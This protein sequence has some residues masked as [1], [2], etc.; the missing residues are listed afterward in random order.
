MKKEFKITQL[1]TTAADLLEAVRPTKDRATIITLSGDLGAGK[2]TL[3]QEIARILGVK[4]NIISPTFVI[5]KSYTT[6]HAVFK[7]LVHI[8]AYRLNSSEELKRLG[9][10]ELS[11]D[12]DSLI[13]LEWP[14]RVPE[15]LDVTV[16]KVA[17]THIDEDTRK[18]EFF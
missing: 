8:D 14:E 11:G 5:M 16:Q 17:L 18:I 7:K 9:W 4:Q 10:E 3:T 12:R 15:C 2:T 13:I 1:H 6:N